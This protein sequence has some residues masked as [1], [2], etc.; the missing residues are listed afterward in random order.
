[1]DDEKAPED[2]VLEAAD[3]VIETELDRLIIYGAIALL[4]FMAIGWAIG[5]L[6]K[7]ASGVAK[8]EAK[9]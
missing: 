1:M 9:K 2:Q 3:D 5:W 7:S 6:S 8:S 4:A